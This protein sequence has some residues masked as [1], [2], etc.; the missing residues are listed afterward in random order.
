[1]IQFFVVKIDEQFICSI[2][3]TYE[4]ALEFTRLPHEGNI[5]SIYHFIYTDY[6]SYIEN[7]ITKF[8][9]KY[10]DT[11]DVTSYPLTKNIV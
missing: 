10:S 1:M 8:P 7:L 6:G 5:Y 11:A 4:K 2:F 9:M 3:S